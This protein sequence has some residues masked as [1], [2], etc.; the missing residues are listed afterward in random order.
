MRVYFLIILLVLVGCFPREEIQPIKEIKGEVFGS[1]YIIKYRGEPS[2]DVIKSILDPFFLNFNKEFSTYRP[3]S[4]ISSFNQS[5]SFRKLKVSSRFIE[6]LKLSR[7]FHDST[8]GAFDPTLGPVI[9][10]WGFGGGKIKKTPSDQEI[11]GALSKVGFHHIFW[12]EKKSL[13]WKDS[14]GVELDVNAFAPGWAADLIGNL[15]IEKNIK[16][17]MIDISGE[18]LFK[19]HRNTQDSWIA[20]IERPSNGLA[21]EVQLGLRLSDAAISTSGNY[22][23][24]FDDKGERRSHI[25]DPRTGKPVAH[26]VSSASVIS[27]SAAEADAWSTAMMV[28]GEEGIKLS[29]KSGTKVFLLVAKKSATFSEVMSSSMKNYIEAHGM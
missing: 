8:A 23:Q 4:V 10:L 18:I 12:D 3:D 24:Y 2:A 20:G 11:K 13:V 5:R 15:L 29:E 27:D 22:R 6:M 1:Y 9:K 28:L 21:K 25:I 17:F 14:D 26:F 7:D 19:G 16:D